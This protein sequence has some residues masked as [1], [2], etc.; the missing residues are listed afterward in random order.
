MDHFTQLNLQGKSGEKPQQNSGKAGQPASPSTNTTQKPGKRPGGNDLDPKKLS[1][2]QKAA[3]IVASC[4]CIG[5]LSAA[6]VETSGCSSNK[7]A[8]SIAAPTAAAVAPAPAPVSAPAPSP[9]SQPVAK[10]VVKKT[11]RRKI[12]IASYKNSDYGM[13]FHYPKY[14]T[15]KEGE[16]AQMQWDG[17]G[18][19][20]MN[21]A[22]PGGSTISTVEMPDDMFPN[23][24]Y[25]GAFFTASV[26]AKLSQAECSQFAF[27]GASDKPVK[28]S[29]VK[30]GG[31]EFTE[32][33][34]V[35]GNSK[36]ADAKYYHLYQN[37][38]CYEFTLGLQTVPTDDA[39]GATPVD[40][41]Q[42]FARLRWILKSVKINPEEKAAVA[43]S[44]AAPVTSGELMKPAVTP[45]AAQPTAVAPSTEAATPATAS[46]PSL[47]TAAPAASSTSPVKVIDD[48]H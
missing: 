48:R 26:N 22:Q 38:A 30:M 10:K 18:P 19:V 36:Q 6:L 29:K 24:D 7:P 46:A 14:D 21:F 2:S 25:D 1:G 44:T 15:L 45:G 42:V 11:P 8:A 9:T 47:Q 40:R 12:P 35:A 31:A 13:T 5:L 27:P 17:I 16:Q 20:E 4:I 33:E 39:D 41:N 28:T 37:G 3:A 23:T 32:V 43:A 34:S